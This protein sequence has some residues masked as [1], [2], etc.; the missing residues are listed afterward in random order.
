[1]ALSDNTNLL[2]KHGA[3]LLDDPDCEKDREATQ[4]K[5]WTIGN[6]VAQ[7]D[8]E[9]YLGSNYLSLNYERLCLRPREM[10]IRLFDF[11]EVEASGEII[12]AAC[13]LIVPSPNI[14]KWKTTD[15]TLLHEPDEEASDALRLFGYDVWGQNMDDTPTTDSV[16]CVG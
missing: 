2:C 8:G 14:G 15:L 4:L 3:F 10:L 1:M 7:Y 11:L 6:R 12:E 16:R 9:K 13:R 5:L